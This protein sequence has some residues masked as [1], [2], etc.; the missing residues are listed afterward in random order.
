MPLWPA[1]IGF[2]FVL[3]LIAWVVRQWR[4]KT[5]RRLASSFLV[6]ALVAYLLLELQQPQIQRSWVAEQA[7]MPK[8]ELVGHHVQIRDLR[9]APLKQ[10]EP[11]EYLDLAFPLTRL[12]KL[13]FAIEPLEGSSLVAHTFLSFGVESPAGRNGGGMQF[14]NVSVEVRREEGEHYGP[15]MGMYNNFELMYVFASDQDMLARRSILLDDEIYLL[16]LR[17]PPETIQR[18][19]VDIAART[20]RLRSVPEFYHTLGNNCTTSIAVH[21]NQIAGHTFSRFDPRMIVPGWS[22]GLL[23]EQGLVETDLSRMDARRAFRIDDVL[24]EHPITEA[25]WYAIRGMPPPE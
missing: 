11:I 18:L 3:A 10:E 19:F 25:T 22:D 15:L 9:N 5:W 6:P 16:P 17:V 14:F 8:V 24:R 20:N 13:W 12:T 7:R 23:F 2:L 21:V 1:W 4:L